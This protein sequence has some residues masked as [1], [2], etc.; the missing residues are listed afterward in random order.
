MPGMDGP[1]TLAA[2]KAIE[3]SLRCWF[4]TGEPGGY[5]AEGLLA[6]GAERVLLKPFKVP[7]LAAELRQVLARR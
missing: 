4:M 1:A 5:T 3:P 7:E 2:L 6:P